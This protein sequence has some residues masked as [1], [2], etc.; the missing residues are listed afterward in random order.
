[1]GVRAT[2]GVAVTTVMVGLATAASWLQGPSI[3]A[4][5]ETV[6]REYAGVYQWS[7]D[8]FVYL[9][10]WNELAGTSQLVAF[11]ESSDVRT[12]YPIGADRF[13]SGPG[14]ALSTPVESRIEFQRDGDGAIRS[15]TWQRGRE[16]GRTATRV[17]IERHEEVRF[18]NG[19]LQLAGTLIR[20][21][22]EGTYPAIILVHYSG[23]ASRESVL[24]FARFLVRHGISVFG[25]DKRGVGGS[26]G[27]WN[28]ASFE[29]LA[30]DVVAAFHYLKMR[31]DIDGAKIGL[32]GVSQA[33]WIMPIAAVRAPDL[34]F[35]ISV[36]GAGLPMTETT[37]DSTRNVMAARGAPPQV[38]DQVVSIMKLQY[39]FA[40]TGRGWDEYAALRAKLAARM[41][42]PPDTFPATPDHPYWQFIR[43]LVRYDPTPA[44][45]ALR[46]PALSIFGELDDNIL[47]EK[48]KAAWERALRAGGHPDYTLQILAG[49]NHLQ[50][51]APRMSAELASIRRFVPAY[52]ATV[53][54]WLAK[55]LQRPASPAGS[56][57]AF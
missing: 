54:Q 57:S 46:V 47:A 33:G 43:P 44:L 17:A 2:I 6:L 25:Y 32:L 28:T 35:L 19:E 39:D 40:R 12:L 5:D 50:L 1:M 24:P 13:V 27:D 56:S 14:V 21:A 53:H 29:D 36:S 49:A 51:E 52:A 15:L 22:R 41:G 23:P 18:A 31:P 7:D 9:Q 26:T 37:I 42:A 10:M 38:V 30:G 45:E 3:R 16:S 4:V 34:A 8:A 55:R 48:N 11:D 20:P